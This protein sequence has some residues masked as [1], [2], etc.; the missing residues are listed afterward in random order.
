MAKKDLRDTWLNRLSDEDKAHA[1]WR[2]RAADADKAYCDYK[3]EEPGPLF[4]VFYTTINTIHGRIY[5]RPPKPDVR[6]RHPSSPLQSSAPQQQAGAPQGAPPP[7]AQAGGMGAQLPSASVA[8]APGPVAAAQPDPVADDNTIA[9]TLERSLGYIIDTTM[10]DRD[11]HQAVNDFLIAAC[12]VAKIEMET[13]TDQIPVLNPITNQ[14]IL[15]EEGMPL[16]QSVIAAQTLRL[17]HFHHSQ[18]RWEPCKDWSRCNWVSFDHFM[19][20]DDIEDEFGVVLEEG[21]GTGEGNEGDTQ[22]TGVKAPQRDKYEGVYTVHEI[23]DK[24]TKRQIFVSDCYPKELEVNDDPLELKDFFPCPAPMMANVS[25]RELL[26]STEYW[27][28]ESLCKHADE[29]AGRIQNI[30]KQVKDIAFYDLSF[31]ELKETLNY[32]DGSFIGVKDLL[33]RLRS[34]NATATTESVICQLPMQAKTEVLQQ[35]ESQLELVKQRIYEING[36]ADIQRGISNPGDTATAQNIKNEWADIRTGQ[37]VQVVALFFRDVFRLMA[38]IISKKFVRSEIQAMTGIPLSDMQMATMRSEVAEDY[39]V[40]VESDST[41]IQN[42]ST[43]QES[44]MQFLQAFMQYLP[45]MSQAVQAGSIPGD[46]AREILAE[47]IDA[48]K[49]GRDLQQAVEAIPSTLQQLQGLQKQIQDGQQQTQQLQ[50]QNQQLQQQVQQQNERK[51]AREDMRAQSD[52]QAKAASTQKTQVDARKVIQDAALESV[53]TQGLA[54]DVAMKN[55][56]NV[57]EGAATGVQ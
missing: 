21:Y 25:G 7:A 4:P 42:D 55:R 48:F 18:F 54:A 8:P 41:M 2:K 29:I 43:N 14:P 10:F 24:R 17:R 9:L 57:I 11:A 51:E 52:V 32:S 56:Q 16:Q 35:L 36:I 19:T 31:G 50:E 5:G 26:P 20:K 1:T 34:A 45:Q 40:D 12:G 53:E 33:A 13:E 37:R 27:Q 3:E 6:K 15:D 39:S 47:I 44:V 38:E 23:W 22:A 49:A 46:L 28:Y 30:T